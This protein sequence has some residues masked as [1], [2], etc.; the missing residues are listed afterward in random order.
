MLEKFSCS[1]SFKKLENVWLI[2]DTMNM[3]V[4]NN[5]IMN[6]KRALIYCMSLITK[7]AADSED[8][9]EDLQRPVSIGK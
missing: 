6:Y 7:D 9:G 3:F 8:H 1:E 4:Q 2:P 5:V